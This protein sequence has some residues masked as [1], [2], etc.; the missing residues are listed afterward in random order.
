MPPKMTQPATA[1]TDASFVPLLLS[2]STLFLLPSSNTPFINSGRV[3]SMHP[4]E[5]VDD[6]SHAL[7][8][9]PVR[10]T[11]AGARASAPSGQH[12]QQQQQLQQ[13]HNQQQQQQQQ[14]PHAQRR[15]AP[16]ESR[17]GPHAEESHQHQQTPTPAMSI[18]AATSTTDNNITPPSSKQ[19]ARPQ[20]PA[21]RPSKSDSTSSAFPQWSALEAAM[22]TVQQVQQME[23]KS[24]GNSFS[25]FICSCLW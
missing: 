10:T 21:Q 3:D 14:R 18:S 12:P 11:G 24:Q 23:R 8:Q 19:W 9:A 25:L 2:S 17:S 16:N 4:Q 22:N 15:S 13:L 5:P 1:R 6:L 20:A 7:T